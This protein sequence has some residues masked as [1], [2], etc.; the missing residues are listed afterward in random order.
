[1]A[2]INIRCVT[3][4]PAED[5][6]GLTLDIVSQEG[7]TSYAYDAVAN[8]PVDII[9]D[10]TSKQPQVDVLADPSITYRNTL[11]E[12]R[13]GYSS[14]CLG[15][16]AKSVWCGSDWLWVAG[17]DGNAVSSQ[18]FGV[19]L[20]AS[21]ICQQ[22]DIFCAFNATQLGEVLMYRAGMEVAKEALY[23]SRINSETLKKEAWAQLLNE[24]ETEYT[25][26]IALLIDSSRGMLGKYCQACIKCANPM[27]GWR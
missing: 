24:W 3:L 1:M 9:V 19:A 22:D 6:T 2:A 21:L 16:G 23:G 14:G 26:K 25:K 13:F 4:Y 15:C 8:V 5:A 20:Q 17:L 12:S 11:T 7:T 27:I 18:T 10:Y